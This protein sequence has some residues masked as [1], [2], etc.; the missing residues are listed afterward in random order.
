[1][2]PPDRNSLDIHE[3]AALLLTLFKRLFPALFECVKDGVE[4]YN[5]KPLCE[6][7]WKQLTTAIHLQ[8]DCIALRKLDEEAREVFNPRA[9]AEHC[10]KLIPA[11]SLNKPDWMS[12]DFDQFGEF[13]ASS[14]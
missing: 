3:D 14:F 4:S 6:D 2:L 10:K 9:R 11:V 12:P 13:L 5:G 1:M 8:Y 7:E